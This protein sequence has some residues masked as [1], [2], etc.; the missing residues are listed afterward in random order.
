MLGV[1]GVR[2]SDPL[3]ARGQV[4]CSGLPDGCPVTAIGFSVVRFRFRPDL[5]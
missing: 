1:M 3:L 2:L 5:V 4:N